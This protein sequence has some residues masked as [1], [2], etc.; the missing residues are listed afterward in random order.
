[1]SGP[2]PISSSRDLRT[3]YQVGDEELGGPIEMKAGEPAA[4]TSGSDG[5]TSN[6]RKWKI[7]KGVIL[8]VAI[9]GIVA[10]TLLS[11]TTLAMGI[12]AM[13]FPGIGTAAGIGLTALGTTIAGGVAIT[14]N[15]VAA[16]A[17]TFVI[18]GA[19][20]LGVMGFSSAAVVVI[21]RFCRKKPEGDPSTSEVS[22]GSGLGSGDITLNDDGGDDIEAQQEPRRLTKEEKK[23]IAK[24][25]AEEKKRKAQAKKAEAKKQ[26][27]DEKEAKEQAK[28]L[29][30]EAKKAKDSRDDESGATLEA[31]GT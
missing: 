31:T 19:V 1:M 29:A 16:N 3:A 4:D 15:F 23:Q 8:G 17:T 5:V 21:T 20:G 22:S 11:L 13:F 7:I 24:E 30:K 12:A 9:A 10:G 2:S 26:K 18:V 28:R 6:G 25:K 27:A 14:L